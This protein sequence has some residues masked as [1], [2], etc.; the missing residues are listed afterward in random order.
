MRYSQGYQVRNAIQDYMA[1]LCAVWSFLPIATPCLPLFISLHFCAVLTLVHTHG[2]Y[3]LWT[4]R[5]SQ[6]Y[7]VRNAIRYPTASL[8]TVWSFLHITMPCLPVY[9]FLHFRSVLTLVHAHGAYGLWK[10]L[11]SQ[12]YQVRTAIRYSTVSL[13]AEEPVAV[14][15]QHAL[16]AYGLWAMWYSQDYQVR[17]AIPYSKASLCAEELVA[18]RTRFFLS[19]LHYTSYAIYRL[20]T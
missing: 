15:T 18:A 16:G 14:C 20:H 4:M 19:T 17:T 10:M 8:C 11:Y 13:C 6:D 9:I 1:S 7:Q 5:Y 2:A 3:C 12:E